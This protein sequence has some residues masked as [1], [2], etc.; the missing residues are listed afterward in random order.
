MKSISP[1]NNDENGELSIRYSEFIAATLDQRKYLTQEKIRG[2]FTYF[3]SNN[4]G[5]INT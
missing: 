1:E 2:L 5:F 4:S 3:D